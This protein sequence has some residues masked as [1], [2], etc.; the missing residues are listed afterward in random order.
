MAVWVSNNPLAL[1]QTQLIFLHANNERKHTYKLQFQNVFH[2]RRERTR[3][4]LYIFMNECS[5]CE[6]IISL[7]FFSLWLEQFLLF[8]ASEQATHIESFSVSVSIFR[9]IINW[10]R[11]HEHGVSSALSLTLPRLGKKFIE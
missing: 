5:K 2:Y 9:D 6:N 11:R 1:Q 7:S 3:L 8:Q 4:C 10:N